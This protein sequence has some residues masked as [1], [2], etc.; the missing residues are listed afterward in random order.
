LGDKVK[1]YY[2]I[3]NLLLFIVFIFF[4]ANSMEI[5]AKERDSVS[6]R[7][8]SI[9]SAAKEIISS[10]KYCALITVDSTG[11]A[12]VRTMNPFPPEE[13]MSVWM[14]TNSRSRKYFE[15]KKNPKVT[16]YYADHSKADGYVAITGRAVLVDD[17]AEKLK[18]KRAYWDQ[19]FPDWKYL[20]LIKVVPER[21]EVINY[22]R[23]LYN[24]EIT[25]DVPFI[26]F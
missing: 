24:A 15:I 26:D 20:I 10:L 1:T 22:K 17:M 18:R 9:I 7:R 4:I 23:K 12:N 5:N 8:D 11:R 6:T 16:L 3:S 19:S 2:R 14:A 25:W 13:D 21:M